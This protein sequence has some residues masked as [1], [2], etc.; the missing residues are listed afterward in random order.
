MLW[1]CLD[2]LGLDLDASSNAWTRLFNFCFSEVN[3]VNF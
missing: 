2:M 1:T 3:T